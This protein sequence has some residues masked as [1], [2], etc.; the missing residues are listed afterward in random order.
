M[1]MTYAEK[2]KQSCEWCAKGVTLIS[3]AREH[4]QDDGLLLTSPRLGRVFTGTPR[5]CTAPSRDEW[6]AE[7]VAEISRLYDDHAGITRE[8][9]SWRE[10]YYDHAEK[11][12]RAQSEAA[13]LR[14]ELE[15]AQ[16]ALRDLQGAI[17]WEP[18]MCCPGL[19]NECYCHGLPVNG[20]E[21]DMK[22]ILSDHAAALDAARAAEPPAEVQG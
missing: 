12:A 14:A 1:L 16:K 5:P 10:A 2:C 19:S 18:E 8:A 22:A 11:L 3:M 6:E 13:G 4:V 9:V 21:P 7:L 17:Q 15:R 20:P